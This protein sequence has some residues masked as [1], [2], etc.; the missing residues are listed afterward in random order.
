MKDIKM[1]MLPKTLLMLAGIGLV[2]TA[3]QGQAIW[4]PGSDPVTIGRS[5]TGVA[6]GR[7]LEACSLNPA[8]LVTLQD[9]K[10][11]FLSVGMELQATQ[12][13]L[14]SNERV[15]YSSDRNRFLPALG[16]S[17]RYSPKLTFGLK[18]D[19]PFLRHAE[20]PME[21][22]SRFFGQ[23]IDLTTLRTE[24]Q[25]GYAVTPAFSLGLSA[26]M[27]KID[28]ASQL[29]LRSLVP[30]NP[31]L[32]AGELNPA[33]VL[34]ETTA[35]Q[36]GSV[37]V[38]SFAVGFRYAATSR[39]TLAGSFTSGLKGRPNL[40]T[41]MP[42][43]GLDLFNERGFS[44]PAPPHGSEERALVLLN[45]MNVKPGSGDV[46]LPHKIQLGV[47][48]RFSQAMTWEFDLRYVG[49]SVI[50]LP[51]QPT[52][53]TPSGVVATMERTYKFMDGLGFCG[54]LEL[55]LNKDWTARAGVSY[56]PALRSGEEV[57]AMLGGA[58]VASFSTG[59]SYKLLGGELSAGYQYRQA[60]NKE[61]N[62]VEGVWSVY[63]LATTGTQTRV[64]GMGHIW[65][66]GF[67]KSF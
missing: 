18:V 57:E 47:R 46:A 32:P 26:G 3:V 23:G 52:I 19:N 54:M 28:Y 17:L 21:S 66:V 60:Q 14:P 37:S 24:L 48:Q 29:S 50:E 30:N 10:S 62:G 58:K 13:T 67:K 44:T 63:G 12:L 27:T 22:S 56:D 38:P 55:T 53:D 41:S 4:L 20:L 16:V 1:C 6:F 51:G 39:W 64:E 7:S 33:E 36:E 40:S 59:L 2:H 8:L 25:A 11:G 49:A 5:G 35:R 31:E 65:S 43:R 9:Q 15:L 45:T 34:L 42:E 61:A